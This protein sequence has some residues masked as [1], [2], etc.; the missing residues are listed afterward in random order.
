MERDIPKR[1]IC[2]PVI[3][4]LLQAF[5][6]PCS[7]FVGGR[8]KLLEFPANFLHSIIINAIMYLPKYNWII[9]QVFF[10]D[11][12]QKKMSRVGTTYL[13]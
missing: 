13:I 1:K 12:F 7:L 6:P 8:K 4:S 2:S 9:I 10:F 3:K 5:F 11:K